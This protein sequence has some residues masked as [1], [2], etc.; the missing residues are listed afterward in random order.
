MIV[1]IRIIIIMK[2]WWIIGGGDYLKHANGC[3]AILNET[4]V[5]WTFSRQTTY[6]WNDLLPSSSE[7]GIF[8]E[9]IKL[10]TPHKYANVH[11]SDE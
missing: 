7:S 5:C 8:K 1:R 10:I 6:V 2:I 11:I 4:K 3:S 9:V